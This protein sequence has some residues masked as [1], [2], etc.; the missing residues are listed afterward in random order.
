MRCWLLLPGSSLLYCVV[1]IAMHTRYVDKT[2]VD[3]TGSRAAHKKEEHG[4]CLFFSIGVLFLLSF[5]CEIWNFWEFYDD[6]KLNRVPFM[7]LK[8]DVFDV[9]LDLV[10]SRSRQSSHLIVWT[11]G[12]IIQTW[13]NQLPY[14]WTWHPTQN[15]NFNISGLQSSLEVRSGYYIVSI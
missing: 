6:R 13:D 11:Y 15:R 1:L 2:L 7:F 9:V 12:I 3:N 10:N 8:I 14:Q 4:S 5:S